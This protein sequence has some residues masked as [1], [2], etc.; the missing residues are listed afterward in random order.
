[1]I[2]CI[3]IDGVI[4]LTQGNDYKNS[5]PVPEVIAKVNKLFN[6]GHAIKIFT[7]RGSSSHIDWR[8]LTVKQL[9]EWGVEYHQLIMSKPPADFF[10]DDRAMSIKEFMEV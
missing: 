6:E 1:M 5:K 2:Y 4:A 10:V 8:E 9:Q 3:D 7:A